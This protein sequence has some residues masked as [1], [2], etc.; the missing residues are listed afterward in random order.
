MRSYGL[1]IVYKSY[2][3]DHCMVL[4]VRHP[5]EMI[6]GDKAADKHRQAAESE[7]ESGI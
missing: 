5:C 2:Q 3:M 1:L 6:D 4:K 7:M